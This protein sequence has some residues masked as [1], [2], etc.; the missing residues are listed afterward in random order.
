MSENYNLELDL[1]NT[2]LGTV[3]AFENAVFRRYENE[4]DART[5]ILVAESIVSLL[6]ETLGDLADAKYAELW[7]ELQARLDERDLSE[8]VR[9]AL[10]ADLAREIIDTEGMARR[11][12]ELL[13]VIARALP[14]DNVARFL[15]RVSR[16]YVYGFSPECMVMCRAG[17]EN[18]LNARYQMEHV[19]YPSD[20]DGRQTMKLKVQGAVDRGWL[21]DELGREA[22]Q[23]VWGRGNKAAHADPDAVGAPIEAIKLTMR[24]IE[25]LHAAPFEPSD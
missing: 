8:D 9:F 1:D 18:A 7:P 23:V 2:L 24:S 10:Q 17:F 13:A 15:R 20:S 12:M 19:P 22:F 16:C 21:S 5:I 3:D 25:Q 11:C 14:P 4:E 6:R